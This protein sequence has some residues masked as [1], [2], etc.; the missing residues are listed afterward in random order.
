MSSEMELRYLLPSLDCSP[1]TSP[2]AQF[3]DRL[4]IL[5]T[6]IDRWE[7]FSRYG[8]SPSLFRA[9]RDGG[10]LWMRRGSRLVRW[11]Q[12]KIVDEA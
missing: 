5:P 6:N 9:D 12:L 4:T 1:T 3:L 2:R 11:P 7:G 8:R 10:A